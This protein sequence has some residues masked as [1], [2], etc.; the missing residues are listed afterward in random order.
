MNKS[1]R[2]AIEIKRNSLRSQINKCESLYSELERVPLVGNL[3]VVIR[4]KE[5]L[6]VA[7]DALFSTSEDMIDMAI[8]TLSK[9]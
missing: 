3:S 6:K 2:S 5:G 8:Q 7:N 1:T 9:Y 4:L